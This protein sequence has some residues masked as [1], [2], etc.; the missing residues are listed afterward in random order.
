M[1]E[2]EKVDKRKITSKNNMAKARQAKLDKLKEEKQIQQMY[3]QPMYGY[4]QDSSSDSESSEE[5]YLYINP[6]KPPKRSSA[7]ASAIPKQTKTKTKKIEQ[8]IPPNNEY[9]DL[10]RELEFL[11]MQMTT[12]PRRS[13]P[14]KRKEK[15]IYMPA[16]ATNPVMTPIS[17]VHVP[18]QP[19]APERR[20]INWGESIDHYKNQILNHK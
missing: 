9:N 17:P 6:K 8:P 2:Q 16:S 18:S 19:S 15:I 4:P 14:V 3:S 12:R 13:T 11:K 20:Y 7:S 1:N 10:K 5:E